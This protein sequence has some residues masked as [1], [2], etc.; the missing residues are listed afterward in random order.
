MDAE[1]ATLAAVD[2]DEWRSVVDWLDDGL[3]G[4]TRGRLEAEYPISLRRE[5]AADQLLVREGD[6]PLAHAMIHR[7]T[8]RVGGLRLRLGMIGLVY[9]EEAARGRG[10]ASRCVEA[11]SERLRSEDIPLAL[12]WSDRQDFYRR[13]GFHPAGRERF[14]FVDETVVRRASA[15]LEGAALLDVGPPVERE[16]S[17]LEALY[18]AKPFRAERSPGE[19]ARLAAGPQVDLRVAHHRG[20]PIAYAALGR[21]DDFADVVHEWAGQATGVLACLLELLAER[22]ALALMVG[23]G[24]D[25]LAKLLD[26]A[27]AVGKEGSFALMRLLD[28]AGLWRAIAADRPELA[29]VALANSRDGVR[30]GGGEGELRLNHAQALSLLFGGEDAPAAASL[31]A[32]LTPAEREAVGGRLPFPLYVWGFDSI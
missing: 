4:G 31:H 3:R 25:L 29:R 27:G 22:R 16:W 1:R 2:D 20:R 13:L 15:R 18:D 11:C 24:A 19:L 9:T 14:L 5:H 32:A 12:L 21:G 23:P 7:T 6:R 28:P 30:L 17:A 10:L 8:A 26:D